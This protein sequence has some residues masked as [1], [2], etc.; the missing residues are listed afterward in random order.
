MAREIY[1]TRPRAELIRP[2]V[3]LAEKGWVLEQG[4]ADLLAEATEDFR[5]DPAAAA[6]FLKRDG[7]PLEAGD[8]LVQK[9]LARTLKAIAVKGPSGFYQGPVAEALI[10]ANR[11]GGGLLSKAD[12]IQ[13]SPRR[14]PPIESDYRGYRVLAAPPPSSGGVAICEMLNILEGYPLK[15]WGFRSAKA[16]HYQIEAMRHAY[17][18][19]NTYLGDPDFVKNP[20]A[21]LI[22]KGYAAEI[23]AAIK[24]D[25]AGDSTKIKPGAPP[26]EGSNTTHYSIADHWGNAVA[27]TYTINDW[28][29]ARV[30]AGGTG[31][32]LNDEMDDFT[33]KPG[34]PNIYGLVQGEANAIAPGKRPLSSMSRPLCAKT[35]SRC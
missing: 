20:V 4:D 17:M 22:D 29:G 1:G 25:K 2:A 8:R 30:M 15:E 11:N 33:S 5:K 24:P 3:L 14:M 26:H 28:F 6:V 32:L 23:R 27:V 13:Y 19:R 7:L 10:T 18:D 34:E 31:V 12:L 21:R 9:D 16:V 35:A